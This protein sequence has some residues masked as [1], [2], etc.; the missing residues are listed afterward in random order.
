MS[1]LAELPIRADDL[2]QS[3][4]SVLSSRHR[5]GTGFSNKRLGLAHECD[6]GTFALR[7]C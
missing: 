6:A 3:P 2:W 7:A 4:A 1:R 5:D